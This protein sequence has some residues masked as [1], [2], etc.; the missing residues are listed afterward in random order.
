MVPL[1]A[2]MN[3]DLYAML[4]AITSKPLSQVIKLL[5]MYNIS[6]YHCNYFLLKSYLH[7]V[8][9]LLKT[10]VHNFHKNTC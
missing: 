2:D 6:Y 1:D 5:N 8:L 4:K 10:E 7:Q 3:Y 9:R